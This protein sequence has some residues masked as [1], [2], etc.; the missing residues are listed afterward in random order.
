M[1]R[2]SSSRLTH[3]FKVPSPKY[4]NL[5]ID[6]DKYYLIITSYIGFIN[7]H[8]GCES[9]SYAVDSLQAFGIVIK[10]RSDASPWR[11]SHQ[12]P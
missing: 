11:M 5:I 4:T 10:D 6:I 9:C 8:L 7:N 2:P 1:G 12:A 3:R